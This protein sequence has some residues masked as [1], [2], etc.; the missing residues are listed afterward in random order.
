[1]TLNSRT[2][3]AVAGLILAA[4]TMTQAQAGPLTPRPAESQATAATPAPPA[5]APQSSG[6]LAARTA[7]TD[8]L[9]TGATPT[10]P[11][12]AAQPPKILL[13]GDSLTHAFSSNWT[14]RYR[15]WQ[16][17]TEAGQEFDF[18]GPRNDVVEFTTTRVNSQEYRNPG[19]DRDHAALARTRF[20]DGQ[21]QL[22]DLARDYQPSVIVGFIGAND[23]VQGVSLADL[24]EHWRAQIDLARKHS[25]GVDVVLVPLP[26]TWHARFVDYNTMLGE[27]AAEMDSDRARVVVAPLA[28]F[29]PW[30]DTFDYTHLSTSGQL[31]VAAVVAQALAQLGIGSGKLATTPDPPDDFTWAP[32]PAAT[33]SGT[34]VTVTWPAVTYASSQNVWTRDVETGVITSKRFVTGQST[35]LPGVAGH[36]YDL[37]LA[38][39][40]GFLQIGTRSRTVRVV[41][42]AP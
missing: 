30:T 42:P 1:M 4:S 5:A 34:T 20:L 13:Y 15:L 35:T 39:V 11:P 37:W 36:S 29:G 32:Q 10:E 12:A 26:Q 3:G 7:P 25:Y 38:P 28:V 14:W 24:D 8:D 21:Y 27:V 2:M 18:V 33:V 40:Q 19:F 17:L 22:E 41:V 6:D 16:S 9:P 31:K 23:L